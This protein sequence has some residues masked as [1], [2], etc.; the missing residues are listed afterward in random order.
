M[1]HGPVVGES[2]VEVVFVY[3]LDLYVDSDSVVQFSY[4]VETAEFLV[5]SFRGQFG[6]Y[7]HEFGEASVVFVEDGVVDKV[8]KDLVVFLLAKEVFDVYPQGL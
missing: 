8:Q 2:F 3:D 1:T 7:L 5:L 4:P 6:I